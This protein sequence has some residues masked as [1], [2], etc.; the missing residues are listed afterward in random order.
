M[1]SIFLLILGLIAIEVL[2]YHEMF[3]AITI[4]SILAFVCTGFAISW[5]LI[6]NFLTMNAPLILVSFVVYLLVGAI[7][8][9][10]K[11]YRYAN[12]YYKEHTNEYKIDDRSALITGWI[13]WFPFV[14]FADLLHDPIEFIYEYLGNVYDTIEKNARLKYQDKN[15]RK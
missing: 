7:F 11:W 4:L 2:A 12:K 8:S 15:T 9:I 5:T 10:F 13:A 14:L 1:I 6:W 3:A